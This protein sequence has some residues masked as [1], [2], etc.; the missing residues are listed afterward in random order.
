MTSEPPATATAAA[1]TTAGP[2]A[3]IR[4]L[5]VSFGGIKALQGVSFTIPR[6]AIMGLIG[7]NGAGKTTL[8]NCLSRLYTPS[9]GEILFAGRSILAEPKWRMA[10]LGIARTF[11]NVSLFD[12]MSVRDNVLVGGH[13]KGR[14]GFIAQALKT[15]AARRERDRLQARATEAMAFMDIAAFAD[16]A[17][18]DLPFPIRKRVEL[19]RAL[20]ISP[21]L[22]LLDEPAAGLN[23]EEVGVLRGQI[24]AIRDRY[25][26]TVLLVE[27]HMNLVMSVSDTVVAI[28][29]G[30]KIADG[31]PAQVQND[32]AVIEA[33]LGAEL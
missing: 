3:E 13:T 5:T 29:F 12:K 22:L 21:Q 14:A 15:P 32:P 20:M 27:H 19:A 2:L 26:L 28:D 11:Q 8:F 6:R 9:S 24:Q 23:H 31:L 7:P 4:D 10:E 16:R 25:G 33:Y 17:A 18:G 1:G 30:R